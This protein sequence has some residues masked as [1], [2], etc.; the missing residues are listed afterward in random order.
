MEMSPKIE[1][2]KAKYEEARVGL[3]KLQEE[4]LMRGIEMRPGLRRQFEEALRGLFYTMACADGHIDENEVSFYNYLFE[5]ELSVTT[6]ELVR[7]Q[8]ARSRNVFEEDLLATVAA[9]ASYDRAITGKIP[10]DAPSLSTL[11]LKAGEAVGRL[12]I[13]ADGEVVESE[14]QALR[15]LLQQAKQRAELVKAGAESLLETNKDGDI[16]DPDAELARD[17]R[18]L[19]RQICSG[20][21]ESALQGADV[22]IK[23]GA[24]MLDENLTATATATQFVADSIRDDLERGKASMDL[25]TLGLTQIPPVLEVLETIE[26]AGDAIK[27]AWRDMAETTRADIKETLRALHDS[28]QSRVRMLKEKYDW[29]D[30]VMRLEQGLEQAW[31]V[32]K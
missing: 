17:I 19:E 9:F 31:E 25:L 5:E 4:V 10:L 24:G 11:L 29:H 3:D 16:Y 22:I 8:L 7:Q 12:V 30:D 27:P 28:S 6:F 14:A 21:T 26:N 15:T 1:K 23:S 32:L 20:I 13:A 18:G 2:L